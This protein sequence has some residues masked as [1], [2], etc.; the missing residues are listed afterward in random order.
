MRPEG[1]SP[2]NRPIMKQVGDRG[3]HGTGPATAP[4]V[5][6]SDSAHDSTQLTLPIR[7]P[8]SPREPS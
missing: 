7:E 2:G 6:F 8:N 3:K 1:V 5:A 4:P